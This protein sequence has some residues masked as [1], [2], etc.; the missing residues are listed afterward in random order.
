VRGPHAATN[1][2]WGSPW[3]RGAPAVVDIP[4][5]SLSAG[6]LSYVEPETYPPCRRRLL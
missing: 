5:G 1:F 4:Y 3:L 2:A 6:V